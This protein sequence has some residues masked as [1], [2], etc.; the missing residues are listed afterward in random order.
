[1]S[2]P[3]M[4]F[5]DMDDPVEVLRHNHCRSNDDSWISPWESKPHLPD[6]LSG[7]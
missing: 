6:Y 7:L 5:S 3:Y 2:C 4:L 1:M